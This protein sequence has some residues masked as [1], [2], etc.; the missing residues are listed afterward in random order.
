ML[1]IVAL[2]IFT[3]KNKCRIVGSIFFMYKNRFEMIG[4][5]CFGYKQQ[6]VLPPKNSSQL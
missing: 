3:Y 2:Q 1:E 6:I 4:W 5:V